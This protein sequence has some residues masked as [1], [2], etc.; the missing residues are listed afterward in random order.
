MVM[1]NA[2]AIFLILALVVVLSSQQTGC[3]RS[4]RGIAS[5]PQTLPPT[6]DETVLSVI[7]KRNQDL[8][9]AY[10]LA[11]FKSDKPVSAA[12]KPAPIVVT[13]PIPRALTSV[14]IRKSRL[15]SKRSP[16]YAD[17]VHVEGEGRVIF[18]VSSDPSDPCRQKFLVC[19]DSGDHILV[20]YDAK[21][22]KP[23][24][25]L[26]LGDAVEFSGEFFFGQNG[27]EV[28]IVRHE[29][30]EQSVKSWVKHNGLVYE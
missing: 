17:N 26:K 19:L 15:A 11:D 20:V 12:A 1:K 5:Q 29:S 24:A 18:S 8:D 30:S 16:L 25:D 10:S 27:N 9:A 21:Q 13:A 2:F 23:I 14:P 7:E 22:S 4:Y 3:F 28:R 6:K